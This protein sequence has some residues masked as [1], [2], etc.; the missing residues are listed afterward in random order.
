MTAN[1][2]N[3]KKIVYKTDK[4]KSYF[5]LFLNTTYQTKCEKNNI[6]CSH[7]YYL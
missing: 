5:K 4:L 2:K 6:Y 1:F 7:N 3:K